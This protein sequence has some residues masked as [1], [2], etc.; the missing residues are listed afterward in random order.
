MWKL[1]FLS[2]KA[3]ETYQDKNT[4]TVQPL[5]VY[6]VLNHTTM[7]SNHTTHPLKKS[8]K[9][10]IR[11]VM[12]FLIS[13]L[14]LYFFGRPLFRSITNAKLT[15]SIQQCCAR[16]W[17]NMYIAIRQQWQPLLFF[18]RPFFLYNITTT[19]FLCIHVGSLGG[20]ENFLFFCICQVLSSSVRLQ[21]IQ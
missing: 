18:A 16:V 13:I 1:W 3:Q 4:N 9:L 8:T 21:A 5:L 15:I 12:I 11:D 17:S 7:Q 20:T 10:S 6:W 19:F 2:F 14:M